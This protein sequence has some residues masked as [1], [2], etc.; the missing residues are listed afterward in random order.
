MDKTKFLKVIDEKIAMYQ[1]RID[2]RES[3]ACYYDES[4]KIEKFGT[5]IENLEE[6][7]ELL[8]EC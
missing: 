5:K 6:V 4:K 8:D 3:K 1:K 2:I 7:K